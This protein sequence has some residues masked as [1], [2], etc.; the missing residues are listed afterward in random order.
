[1]GGDNSERE[2]RRIYM[3]HEQKTS[4]H[5]NVYVNWLKHFNKSRGKFSFGR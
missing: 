2:S 5:L 4:S 1:M 3:Q